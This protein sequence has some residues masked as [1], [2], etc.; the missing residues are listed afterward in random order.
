MGEGKE[1]WE[2]KKG[3]RTPKPNLYTLQLGSVLVLIRLK[4]IHLISACLFI[5]AEICRRLG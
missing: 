3:F 2:G 5:L 1:R 4:V